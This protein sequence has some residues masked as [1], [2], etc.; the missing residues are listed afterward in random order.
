M[1]TGRLTLAGAPLGN[2]AD[3]SARL[4]VAL[5]Q[6]RLIF[7][8]DTRRLRHLADDLAL[9]IVG[10]VHSFLRVMS[11]SGSRVCEGI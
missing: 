5:A 6:A 8:E 1:N 10:E 3:A 9:T 11:A 2:P 4:Q 7:A